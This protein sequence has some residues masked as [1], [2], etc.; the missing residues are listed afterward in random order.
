MNNNEQSPKSKEKQKKSS[1]LIFSDGDLSSENDSDSD[2]DPEND[3]DINVNDK[4]EYKKFLNSIFPSTYLKSTIKDD[5]K[6]KKK[7][8]N[9][10]KNNKSENIKISIKEKKAKS[11]KKDN[12]SK[13]SKK[14]NNSKR[15]KKD[16]N[17]KRGKEKISKKKKE[18][19]KFPTDE[20]EE[21]DEMNEM[22]MNPAKFSI[23]YTFGDDYD[24][25]EYDYEEDTNDCETENDTDYDEIYE[26][27]I[28]DI[29]EEEWEKVMRKEEEEIIKKEKDRE[30]M[31]KNLKVNDIVKVKK[32][33]WSG[34]YIGKITKVYK[35]KKFFDITLKN[36]EFEPLIKVK[37][38]IIIEKMNKNKTNIPKNI[39]NLLLLK[40]GNPKKYDKKIKKYMDDLKEEEEIIN[41]KREKKEKNLNS[42]RL[43]KLLKEKNVTNDFSYFKNMKIKEQKNIL[44]NLVEI[45]KVSTIKKP[46]KIALIETNI[47]PEIKAIAMKKVNLLTMMDPSTGDYYKNKLWV[48]TF[49]NIPFGKYASLP[50][51]LSDGLE[52]SQQFMKNAKKILDE[53]V[54]GLNDAKMQIMQMIGGWISNPNAVGTAIAIQGPMGTGK[55]TLVKEGISKILNRPFA[56]IPLGGA[57]D[58]SY[59]E[60][61][62]YTYEGSIWGKIVDTIINCKCMNPVFYFDELDKVSNTP[63][64]EEIIGI[65]THLTDTTQN[66]QFHDKY[67]SNLD[68]D[69]SKALF[70]FSYNHE[71][72]VNAILKDR[73]YQIKTK[74]Y[75]KKD[76]NII[77]KDY[78]IKSIEKNINFKKGEVTFAEGVFEHIIEKLTAKEKG[79]RNFKR[80]LEIIY[81]KLN[82]FRLMEKDTT[83]FEK[84]E[85]INVEFP[86]EVTIEIVDKLIKQNDKDAIPF[87]M[88]M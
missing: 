10:L 84:D 51:K 22:M 49:M 7:V 60:G 64:G 53:S 52:K 20:E 35:N 42:Q 13:S 78:L 79:V 68:F 33:V 37:G 69:L 58:S 26:K 27:K 62:S 83:L 61:H 8:F 43:K 82:L 4:K 70:I 41:K 18:T 28:D 48:D 88:Y 12:N 56:F 6:C 63:K 77:A 73:M 86:F 29:S 54:Y 2:Y 55:T 5:K 3:E 1:E 36:E 17:S 76:K 44:K 45:N 15:G 9:K 31:L 67:F 25:K 47:K 87:G 80:C 30:K 50:I 65:L 59:L 40:K 39:K 23:V 34:K 72:K 75:D 21:E 14:D 32:R 57:T 24:N 46:Y 38:N 16:N 11:G 74:G 81:S 66:S 19:F 85:F 71:D